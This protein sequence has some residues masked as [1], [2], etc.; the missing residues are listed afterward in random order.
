MNGVK[1]GTSQDKRQIPGLTS[2]LANGGR[3]WL[4]GR[5]GHREIMTRASTPNGEKVTV[6]I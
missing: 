4:M 3:L 2:P 1:R 5:A 6:G